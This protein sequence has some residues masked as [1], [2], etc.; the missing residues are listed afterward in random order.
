MNLYSEY[1]FTM[2][3]NLEYVKVIKKDRVFFKRY[4]QRVTCQTQKKKR[5]FF[6]EN[7][8]SLFQVNTDDRNPVHPVGLLKFCWNYVCTRSQLQGGGEKRGRRPLNKNFAP[9]TA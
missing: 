8:V 1:Y 9:Q 7:P 6:G 3:Y 4:K 5:L 2:I